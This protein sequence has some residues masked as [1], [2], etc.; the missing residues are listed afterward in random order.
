MATIELSEGR[1]EVIRFG[2]GPDRAPTL[3][4]LHEGLGSAAQWRDFPAAL[5]AATG[6]GALVYSRFGY[7][8]SDP[9]DQPFDASFMHREALDVL[10]R[11]LDACG[12][13]DPLLVGHSDGASIALIYA[14]AGL[15]A[16]GLALEAPHVFV[17]PL[18]PETIAATRERFTTSEFAERM[19]RHHGAKSDATF[20]AWTGVWLSDEFRG[21]DIRPTL[22]RVAC[23]V[24]VIQGD[25]DE[26]GT[27]E[28]VR[29]IAER[30]SDVETLVLERCGHA[31]HRD[32]PEATLEA[33]RGFV[34]RLI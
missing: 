14:A 12:I 6:C 21:W 17:E 26:Y 20:R 15:P 1:V 2:P 32:R 11:V 22:D 30:A 4:F 5:S 9:L 8:G 13:R 7:G 3:V 18:T 34:E 23:P 27:L 28:Q 10:P 24:L 19:R 31:P 29:A 33:M 16:R 25:A